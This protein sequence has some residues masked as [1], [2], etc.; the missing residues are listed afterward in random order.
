MIVGHFPTRIHIR[1]RTH[2]LLV[3]SW[4]QDYAMMLTLIENEMAGFRSG[5]MVSSAAPLDAAGDKSASDLDFPIT[6]ENVMSFPIPAFKVGWGTQRPNN[7]T[8][9]ALLNAMLSG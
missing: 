5:R 8:E 2:C 4:R 7:L 9:F 1:L 6:P 3:P